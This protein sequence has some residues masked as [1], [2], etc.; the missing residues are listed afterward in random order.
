MNNQ[1][2]LEILKIIK[3]H[4][5]PPYLEEDAYYKR[6]PWQKFG[7]ISSGIFMCWC[8]Y[9]DEIILAK[10]TDDDLIMALEE[11]ERGDKMIIDKSQIEECKSEYGNRFNEI[12]VDDL[13]EVLNGKVLCLYDGEY[14]N[15]IYLKDENVKLEHDPAT[16]LTN[17]F[18][19]GESK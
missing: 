19:R 18:L 7:G 12:T 17:L 1:E 2:K 4:K 10:A 15:F 6:Q 13:L 14:A 5:H 8:W 11:I 16:I 3:Q 9:Y